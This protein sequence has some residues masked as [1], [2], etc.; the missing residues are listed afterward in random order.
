MGQHEEF[1]SRQQFRFCEQAIV[2]LGIDDMSVLIVSVGGDSPIPAYASV[3]HA[4]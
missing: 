3:A 2:P 1:M 4:A